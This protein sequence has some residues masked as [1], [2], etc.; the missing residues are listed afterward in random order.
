MASRSAN[1]VCVNWCT[2]L[3]AL[4]LIL[5]LFAKALP[6]EALPAFDLHTG[7]EGDAALDEA[8]DKLANGAA[9]VATLIVAGT[10]T[11]HTASLLQFSEAA[12]MC[13]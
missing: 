1:H 5:V 10:L 4:A 3:A 8:R 13:V 11:R 7:L 9:R 2:L 6:E 12:W